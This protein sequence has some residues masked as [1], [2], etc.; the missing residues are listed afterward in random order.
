MGRVDY[1]MY[2]NA[3]AANKLHFLWS[4]DEAVPAGVLPS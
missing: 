1:L 2:T 3:P 4:R